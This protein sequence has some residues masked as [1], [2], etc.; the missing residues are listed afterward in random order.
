MTTSRKPFAA[1]RLPLDAS[2][3]MFHAH[4]RPLPCVSLSHSLHCAEK[5]QSQAVRPQTER[6]ARRR[7]SVAGIRRSCALRAT[8]Q[9]TPGAG[10]TSSDEAADDDGVS[11]VPRRKARAKGKVQPKVKV[12]TPAVDAALDAPPTEAGQAETAALLALAGV[13]TAILGEGLMVAAAGF[14]SDDMDAW[15]QVRR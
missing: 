15:V 12:L 14:M 1:S 7:V 3:V 8:D 6:H 5:Q 10:S 13:F 4:V 2:V 9:D 11:F